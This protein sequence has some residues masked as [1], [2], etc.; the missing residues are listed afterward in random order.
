MQF[1]SCGAGTALDAN[2]MSD[3]W[4]RNVV[5]TVAELQSVQFSWLVSGRPATVR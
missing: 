3:G 1:I 4:S 5:I 2:V